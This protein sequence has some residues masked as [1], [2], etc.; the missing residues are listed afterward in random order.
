MRHPPTFRVKPAPQLAH[1]GPRHRDP[2]EA[3][4][5]IDHLPRAI[6]RASFSS[7]LPDTFASCSASSASN[8]LS[9]ASSISRE[10]C[11]IISI[12]TSVPASAR[13][14]GFHWSSFLRA[15]W[16][17]VSLGL[18]FPSGKLGRGDSGGPGS[19]GAGRSTRLARLTGLPSTLGLSSS[20]SQMLDFIQSD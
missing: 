8:Q 18:E 12:A 3:A 16:A 9:N 19:E 4:S 5:Q 20:E 15:L 13:R 7:C 6:S 1:E 10:S 11:K 17:G 14:K 2:S